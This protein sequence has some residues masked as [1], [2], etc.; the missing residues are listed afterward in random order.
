[1]PAV[2][3]RW[4]GAPSVVVPPVVAEKP[5]SQADEADRTRVDVRERLLDDGVD[6]VA[7]GGVEDAPVAE[8]EGDVVR[9][10]GLAEADEVAGSRVRLV[11]RLGRR[12][13]LVRVAR[14]DAPEAPIRHV[15][16]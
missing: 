2:W 8:P 15:D 4:A 1:M 10:P 7:P 13:L 9:L 5:Q 14:D 12:L 3:R 16:E 6:A 11:D